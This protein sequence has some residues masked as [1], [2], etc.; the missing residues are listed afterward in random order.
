MK[1]IILAAGQGTRLLPFTRDHP[2]CLVPVS[3]KAILDHQLEALAAAGVADVLIVG[4]YLIERLEE[5][6]SRIS[7]DA[8]PTL[9]CN[10]F[11]SVANSI[12][13]VWTARAA[14]DTPFILMNGD[15]ILAADLIAN[16]IAAARPGVNL[17]VE[18]AHAFA[19]DDMR[20]AVSGDRITRVGKDLGE[21]EAAHRSLGLIVAAGAEGAR[22]YVASLDAVICAQC[23]AQ[24]FHHA[25]I[26]HC[27]RTGHVGA[28]EAGSP[29]WIEI[30][31]PEDIDRWQA[32]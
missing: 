16:A 29:Q 20:V 27:A 10:P 24:R 13:S 11:W 19:L 17:V 32:R 9:I 6:L 4:G 22:D 31:R 25:V 5:H 26:D 15:T 12:G 18:R 1:A 21:E 8:R 3:G 2:K 7:A 14:M 23:G 30:D 28:I